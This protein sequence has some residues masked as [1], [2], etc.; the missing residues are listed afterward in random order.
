MNIIFI[1]IIFLIFTLIIFLKTIGYGL[2]E[3]K[4][5]KNPYGGI[6]CIIFSLFSI[7]FSNI[8]VWTH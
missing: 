7:I 2:Y 6:A 3:I 1:N 8:M 4:Q 5:E